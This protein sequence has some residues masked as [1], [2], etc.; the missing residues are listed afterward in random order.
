[1]KPQLFFWLMDFLIV[2]PISLLYL[3]SQL[4]ALKRK[5]LF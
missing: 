2:A 5:Y 3:L 1:M 4:R